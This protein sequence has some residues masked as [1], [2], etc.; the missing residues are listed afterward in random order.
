MSLNP[1]KG[2]VHFYRVTITGLVMIILSLNPLKIRVHFY[3]IM[4]SYNKAI[5]MS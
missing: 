2:R 3:N 5:I 4:A 1:L